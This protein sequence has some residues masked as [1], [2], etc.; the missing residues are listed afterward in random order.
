M[1]KT[2]V[3]VDGG[4]W[5]KVTEDDL[6]SREDEWLDEGLVFAF[7]GI[8]GAGLYRNKIKR[9]GIIYINRVGGCNSWV[10]EDAT[11]EIQAENFPEREEEN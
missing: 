7:G 11:E 4:W 6:M 9:D 3:K 1:L 2:Y 10:G 8:Y 5:L